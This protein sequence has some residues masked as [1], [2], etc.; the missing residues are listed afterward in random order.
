MRQTHRGFVFLKHCLRHRKAKS[1]GSFTTTVRR[2]FRVL[3]LFT[4]H[5]DKCPR[6]KRYQNENVRSF[7]ANLKSP[8]TK[9][10]PLEH[11]LWM[12]P[13]GNFNSYSM[14]ERILSQHHQR[15][16]AYKMFK[17]KFKGL[18]NMNLAHA[19]MDTNLKISTFKNIRKFLSQPVRNE[20]L[21]NTAS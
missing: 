3:R 16:A 5:K 14:H 12:V 2:I 18:G 20:V 9:K 8:D 11:S 19:V 7:L 4:P 13:S 15:D 10:C 1:G 21:P 17:P 6:E